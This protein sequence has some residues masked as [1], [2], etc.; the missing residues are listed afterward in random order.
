MGIWNSLFRGGH[1]SKEDLIRSLVTKR[2]SNDPM[3]SLAGFDAD[4]VD[5]LNALQLIST[6]EGSIVTIVE[7]YATMKKQGASDQ[8]IFDGIEAHRSTIGTRTMPSSPTLES[9]TQYRIE[10]E[11][12]HVMPI[13][14]GFVSEAVRIC[15]QYFGC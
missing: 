2:V 13:S 1:P 9:Y 14:S 12:G 3:A 5:S 10:V 15:R 8:Q 11:C 4:M 6:P 7:T